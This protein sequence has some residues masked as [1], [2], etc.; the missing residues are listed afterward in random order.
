MKPSAMALAGVLV[1]APNDAERALLGLLVEVGYPRL[2]AALRLIEPEPAVLGGVGVDPRIGVAA[3]F[4]TAART[5]AEAAQL[6][7]AAAGLPL[8]L[9]SDVAVKPEAVL[10]LADDCERLVELPRRDEVAAVREQ[11]PLL[12]AERVDGSERTGGQSRHREAP[13]RPPRDQ[14]SPR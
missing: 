12:E 13:A 5:T 8:G 6:G 9:P 1:D 14:P 10:P 2:Q 7:H 3:G 11:R 4:P